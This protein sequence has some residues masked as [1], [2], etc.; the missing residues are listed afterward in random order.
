MVS[1]ALARVYATD[2]AQG[3]AW[4]QFLKLGYPGLIQA[5]MLLLFRG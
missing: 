3:R 1:C 4:A 5:I 2:D